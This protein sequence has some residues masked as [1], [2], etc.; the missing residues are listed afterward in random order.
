MSVKDSRIIALALKQSLVTAGFGPSYGTPCGILAP[1]YALL[2]SEG[3]LQTISR[4]D[5]AVGVAVG[6][7][8][9]GRSPMVLMQNSGLG[10]SLNALASLI[11]PY[12]VPILLIISLRGIDHDPTP[13][14]IVM[15]RVSATLLE[16][17]GIQAQVLDVSTLDRQVQWAEAMVQVEQRPAA[18]LVPPALLGWAA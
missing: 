17:C 2:E 10:Q 9:A 16:Q 13:E 7:A 12:R 5:T 6:A 18:L 4:E 14:N 8:L 11:V 1:L 15:G 3:N